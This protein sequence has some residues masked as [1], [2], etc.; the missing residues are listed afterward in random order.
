MF[1]SVSHQR[2]ERGGE[3]G[4]FAHVKPTKLPLTMGMINIYSCPGAFMKSFSEGSEGF[5]R[6]F[7]RDN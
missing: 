7:R 1:Q 5:Q 6:N 2:E 4:C 3:V